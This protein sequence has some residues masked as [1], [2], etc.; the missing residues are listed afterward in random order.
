VDQNKFFM[1]EALK[2]AETCLEA[3]EFPVGCV[4][5]HK[6]KVVARGGRQ[7]SRSLV[8]ELDHA[9]MMALRNLCSSTS[10]I[11]PGEVVIYSTLEPCLMCFSAMLVSGVRKYVY[12]YED[13]MG[14]GTNLPR[15]ELAPLYSA[16]EVSITKNVLREKSL[17]L[18]KDFF[19][20]PDCNYLQDTLLAK[21]TLKQEK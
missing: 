1:E 17:Q 6:E 15:K 11:D 12:S 2:V 4:I 8:N 21:Y 5:V 20:S 3:G 9:E 16:M 14:G 19:S 18:F 10:G 13:V 7:N